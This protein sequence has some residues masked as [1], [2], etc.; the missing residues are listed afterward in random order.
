M[1]VD[2]AHGGQGLP[3]LLNLC[4][5]E[6]AS[7]SNM[8]FSMYPGLTHG[9]FSAILNGGSDEQKAYYLPRLGS[10]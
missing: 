4:F 8:A 2:P 10:G 3:F 1:S 7:S 5:S 6:M 9:A